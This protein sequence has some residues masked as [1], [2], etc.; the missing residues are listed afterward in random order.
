MLPDLLASQRLPQSEKQ[1]LYHTLLEIIIHREEQLIELIYSNWP[2]LKLEP[3][4]RGK[5]VASII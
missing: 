5:A 3:M 4:R 1:C 2:W